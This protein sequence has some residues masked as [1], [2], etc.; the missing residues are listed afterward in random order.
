MKLY[1]TLVVLYCTAMLASCIDAAR[2]GKRRAKGQ[3]ATAIKARSARDRVDRP[4]GP[5]DATTTDSLLTLPRADATDPTAYQAYTSFR[6]AVRATASRKAAAGPTDVA[7]PIDIEAALA[8]SALDPTTL[9]PIA[10][11]KGEEDVFDALMARH[12]CRPGAKEQLALREAIYARHLTMVQ[13]LLNHDDVTQRIHNYWPLRIAAATGQ[14]DMVHTL[15]QDPALAS[16]RQQA[17]Q[18]AMYAALNFQQLDVVR[19]LLETKGYTPA[20][21]QNGALI[22]AAMKNDMASIDVLLSDTRVDLFA[23]RNSVFKY[24]CKHGNLKLMQHLIDQ[25]PAVIDAETGAIL[26]QVACEMG[27][28]EIVKYLLGKYGDRFDPG[29]NQNTALRLA[30]KNGQEAIVGY[31]V[32]HE[33]VRVNPADE[34]NDA[35]IHACEG[36]HVGT[37]KQL[38]KSLHVE[39]PFCTLFEASKEGRKEVVA[40]LLDHL[41]P[42]DADDH[43]VKASYESALMYAC[44][45]GHVDVVDVLFGVE[46]LHPAAQNDQC[47]E[48]AASN[49]HSAVVQALINDG[50]ANP[51]M[52][53]NLPLH[54]AREKKH[55][56]T[57]SILMRDKRVRDLALRQKRAERTLLNHFNA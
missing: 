47:I 10:C 44:Q 42:Y 39:P 34:N 12:A 22:Y 56:E 28:M 7:R 50:R 49:G 3:K 18:E 26:F 14:V 9:L 48:L 57:A 40:F 52:K 54:L 32:A 23:R 5:T 27:H 6:A 13:T 24:A 11:E 21:D 43:V 38:L 36:G 2:K 1:R 29:A 35:F 19:F 33:P 20:Y 46:G 37:A 8:S 51:A 16:D 53:K 55:D 45:G 25:R 17:G 31:L 30:A 41:P 4:V 15:L